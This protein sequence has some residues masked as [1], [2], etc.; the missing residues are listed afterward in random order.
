VSEQKMA[1][2][3]SDDDVVKRLGVFFDTAQH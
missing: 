2:P 1:I 3:A